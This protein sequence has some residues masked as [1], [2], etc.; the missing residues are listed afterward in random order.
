MNKYI[1]SNDLG[2]PKVFSVKSVSE[3]I[4]LVT[5]FSLNGRVIFRGQTEDLSLIPSVGRNSESCVLLQKEKEMLETFKRESFPYVNLNIKN[6]WQWLA[7]AQ[8]N[9]LPTRLLDWT[10][11]PLVALWF[12]VKDPAKN[13]KPCIVWAYL[14]D[15]SDTIFKTKK[16]DSPFSIDR[17]YI[18]FP[19]HVSPFIQAQSGVFTVHHKVEKINETRF[20]PIEKIN[21]SDLLLKK[22]EIPSE[23]ITT[24]RYQLFR[25]GISPA[26]LFPGLMGIAN[27][28]RYDNMRDKDEVI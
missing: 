28:I 23:F 16:H 26:S 2:Q 4:D 9:K 21:N 3:Y 20:V 6:D 11:N 27:K 7:I 13:N 8:H 18:Y 5:Q 12:A 25:V 22:I 10:N 24:A 17:T 15:Q 14:Y 1:K 19:E